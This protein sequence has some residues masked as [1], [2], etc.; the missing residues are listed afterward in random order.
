MAETVWP[1]NLKYLLSGLLRKKKFIPV[2]Y[3]NSRDKFLKVKRNNHILF[4]K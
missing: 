2:L 4:Y 3:Y 1:K